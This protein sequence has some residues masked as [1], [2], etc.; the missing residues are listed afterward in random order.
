[1]LLKIN[2]CQN[3]ILGGIPRPFLALI[4]FLCLSE[5]EICSG[6][7]VDELNINSTFYQK[8]SSGKAIKYYKNIENGT[9]SVPLSYDRLI[10]HK[11]SMKLMEKYNW[12]LT[13]KNNQHIPNSNSFFLEIPLEVPEQYLNKPIKKYRNISKHI[14]IY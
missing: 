2:Y 7:M 10:L 6:G 12:A 1:M 13:L 14:D 9:N 3:F 8:L 5:A 11:P 4:V